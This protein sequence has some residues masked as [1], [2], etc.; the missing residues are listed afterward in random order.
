MRSATWLFLL[1]SALIPATTLVAGPITVDAGWY[2]FCFAG[3]G[4][5]ATAGCTD[6]GMDTTG[7]S[8]TFTAT[9]PVEFRVVDAF[10]SGDTFDV[11]VDG[12]LTPLLSSTPL[13]DSSDPNPDSAWLD[14]A[15]SRLAI[16]LGAGAHSI[17]IFAHDS[18]YGAGGAFASAVS[19]VPEPGTLMLL[20]MGAAGLLLRRRIR[21]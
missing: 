13:G 4:S 5:P 19:T 17:D 20:G 9:G 2:G 11:Y 12:S 6:Q 16:G 21:G 3:A 14:P 15:F 7:N 18:P 8:F 10:M 1:L